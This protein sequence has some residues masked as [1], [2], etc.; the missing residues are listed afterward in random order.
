MFDVIG[1]GTQCTAIEIFSGVGF[2]MSFT[3]NVSNCTE[4]GLPLGQTY[5]AG[6]VQP[7]LPLAGAWAVPTVG[8]RCT[9]VPGRNAR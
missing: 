2:F 8:G 6:D 9:C 5:S 3:N 4:C 1:P 7:A